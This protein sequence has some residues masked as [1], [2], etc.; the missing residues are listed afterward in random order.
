MQH[1]KFSIVSAPIPKTCLRSHELSRKI[2]I[3]NYELSEPRGG[4]PMETLT[5][6]M[7]QRHPRLGK[8]SLE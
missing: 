8:P 4:L 3:V 6:C 1:E 5:F 7:I 2:K